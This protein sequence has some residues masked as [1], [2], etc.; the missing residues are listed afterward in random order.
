[1]SPAPRRVQEAGVEGVRRKGNPGAITA[2]DFFDDV[3]KLRELFARL[4]KA[5]EA[6]R[7]AV[8]PS[9]SYAVSTI[10][11]NTAIDRGQ[12]IVSVLHQF[13]SNTHA[14]E[15]L[16]E[17]S[18]ARMKIVAP[19]TDGPDRTV[20]WNDAIVEAIG[21]DTGVVAMGQVHWADGTPF[22]LVRISQRARE[23]G[24]ALVIDGTQSVG[25]VPFDFE[26]IQPD[27]LVCAAY[28]W[29]LGPYSM[30][31]AYYGGRYDDGVPL[32]ESWMS[33]EG[34]RDFAGLVNPAVTYRPGGARYDVGE[35]SNFALVPMAI[36]ALEL[37]LEWGVERI[38][39]YLK[40]L[41]GQFFP[42]MGHLFGLRLPTD[43]DPASVKAHLLERGI[44]VSV[45]GHSVRVS[46]YLYNDEGDME[47]LVAALSESGA[48]PDGAL[49]R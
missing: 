20:A 1:M 3:D 32:E 12:S 30:G 9:V 46:P 42:G 4:V 6:E 13:P 49:G 45:R 7:V 21:T 34:S 18:G 48:A 33:R 5:P 25:A 35:T 22:D 36:A 38:D 2:D 44:I 37:V 43:V 40:D 26:A 23:V 39:E 11:R 28:K 41:S 10:A 8:V 19:P 27:A 17:G 16:C 31:M 24:A 47:A 15:R 14:W 29:L